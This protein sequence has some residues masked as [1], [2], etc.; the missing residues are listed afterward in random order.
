MVP[1]A[2]DDDAIS[3]VRLQP[4]VWLPGFIEFIPQQGDFSR[5]VHG[6]PAL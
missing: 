2:T 4:D 5:A 3:D 6:E 1:V